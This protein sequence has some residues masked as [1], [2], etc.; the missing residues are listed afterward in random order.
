MT[1]ELKLYLLTEDCPLYHGKYEVNHA[2]DELKFFKDPFWSI[3]WPGGQALT[4]FIIDEGPKI[5]KNLRSKKIHVNKEENAVVKVL[6]IGSGCG[7]SAIAA[8]MAGADEVLANDIDEG[9]CQFFY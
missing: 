5:I 7:A 9:L 1:P 6:D 2:D 3:Y 8:R 4:R